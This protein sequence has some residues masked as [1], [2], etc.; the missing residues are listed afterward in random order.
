[1]GSAHL[2]RVKPEEVLEKRFSMSDAAWRAMYLSDTSRCQDGEW[3]RDWIR[4]YPERE[5]GAMPVRVVCMD[6]ALTGGKGRDGHGLVTLGIC[7]D[8]SPHKGKIAIL[9]AESLDIPVHQL[10]DR[11]LEEVASHK[12]SYLIV[13]ATS[14]GV[15]LIRQS[16]EG[17]MAYHGTN[18]VPVRPRI[19][20]TERLLSLS[21]VFKSGKVI[22]TE[23]A[24]FL[25]MLNRQMLSISRG[26]STHIKDDCGDS[27][28]HGV[29]HLVNIFR[30]GMKLTEVSWGRGST[31]REGSAGQVQW[32]RGSHYNPGGG[33][34]RYQTDPDQP[35]PGRAIWN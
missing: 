11:V 12:A 6:T 23:Y 5:L 35:F 22:C 21:V 15:E 24:P 20:K 31:F 1:M 32:G 13:E 19:N 18:I 8:D 25:D 16:R 33:D 26:T 4:C 17:D 28:L 14:Y 34:S 27:L 3:D 7:G 10:H 9:N 2:A 30:S 29:Q